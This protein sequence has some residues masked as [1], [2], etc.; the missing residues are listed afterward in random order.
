MKKQILLLAILTALII[1]SSFIYGQEL[2]KANQ[3][4][5]DTN[6]GKEVFTIVEVQPEFPAPRTTHF[7]S[8]IRARRPKQ[9]GVRTCV[10]LNPAAGGE[11]ARQKYLANNIQYPAI[12]QKNNIEGIVYVSFI[13]ETDGTLTDIKIIKGIGA[14][15]DEEVV[16]VIKNM[17]KWK[18]GKQNGKTVRVKINMPVKFSLR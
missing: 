6:T 10:I 4:Q 13:I 12:A 17:P 16:R 9:C 7:S 14:G 18:P 1:K 5:A 2:P 11:K 8:T 15:C 3:K